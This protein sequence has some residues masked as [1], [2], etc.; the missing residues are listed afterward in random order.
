M[1]THPIV[2]WAKK[3]ISLQ[4]NNKY[5]SRIKNNNDHK[6]DVESF[7]SQQIKCIMCHIVQQEEVG[8]NCTQH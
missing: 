2:V 1:V 3:M 7:K 6:A 4:Y 8:Q 5:M